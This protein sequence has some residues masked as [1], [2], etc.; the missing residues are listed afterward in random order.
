VLA[1]TDQPLAR[2]AIAASRIPQNRRAKWLR[3]LARELEPHAPTPNAQACRDA[4]SRQRDGISF[5]RLALDVIAVEHLLE[6][7][8]LLRAGVDHSHI[9][10]EAA[11][12][13]FIT[14]LTDIIVG[15]ER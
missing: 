15:H 2:L 8:G 10:I 5:F 4:R 6:N 14:K 13:D 12:A 7:E 1:L 11:L 3:R 9:E